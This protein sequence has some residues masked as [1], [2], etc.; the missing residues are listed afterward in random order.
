[1]IMVSIASYNSALKDTHLSVCRITEVCQHLV[2][3]FRKVLYVLSS[4]VLS[5][6]VYDVSHNK[7]LVFF[8]DY[9]GILGP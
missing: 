3:T 2:A 7:Y 9:R 6:N 4:K 8:S 1:M 5:N